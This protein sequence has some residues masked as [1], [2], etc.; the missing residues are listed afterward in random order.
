MFSRAPLHFELGLEPEAC[1]CPQQLVQFWLTVEIEGFIGT[2]VTTG[3]YNFFISGQAFYCPI[4]SQ[5]KLV[6]NLW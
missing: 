3:K 1:M 2:Y 6:K 4:I 5:R